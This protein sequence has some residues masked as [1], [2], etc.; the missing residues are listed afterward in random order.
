MMSKS[1]NDKVPKKISSHECTLYIFFHL[2]L[3]KLLCVLVDNIA[4]WL[5][6]LCNLNG[7][8][9]KRLSTVPEI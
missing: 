5:G 4:S 8:I 6:F 2:Y 1:M 7:D 3:E 9:P